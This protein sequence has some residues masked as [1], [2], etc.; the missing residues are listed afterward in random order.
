MTGHLLYGPA[1]HSYIMTVRQ[2]L[3][4][5]HN[6]PIIKFPVNSRTAGNAMKGLPSQAPDSLAMHSAVVEAYEFV[7]SY[8]ICNNRSKSRHHL[9]CSSAICLIPSF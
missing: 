3:L 7:L 8:R 2:V 5:I 1:S 9:T 4:I 6:L